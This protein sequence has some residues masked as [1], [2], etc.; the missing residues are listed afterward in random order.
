VVNV[1]RLTAVQGKVNVRQLPAR[2]KQ[3]R[4]KLSPGSIK[5]SADIQTYIIMS[6]FQI[7]A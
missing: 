2:R 6:Q 1:Q 5:L 4:N 7:A 3:R